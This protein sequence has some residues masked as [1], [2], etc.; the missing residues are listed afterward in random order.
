MDGLK[1]R[2]HVYPNPTG[3]LEPHWILYCNNPDHGGACE[4]RKGAT[5]RNEA[6]FGEI[7]P[8][9]Y[10]HA[11]HAIEWPTDPKKATHAQ[12]NPTKAQVREIAERRGAE[13]AEVCRRAGL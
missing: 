8:V 12:E 7:E 6:V 13:L 2:Y 10:L 3:K 5:P 11:W 1:I 9:A 4:K